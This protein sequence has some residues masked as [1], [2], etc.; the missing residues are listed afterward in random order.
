[1]TQRSVSGASG[2]PKSTRMTFAPPSAGGRPRPTVAA[3]A[4][5]RPRA[6]PSEWRARG[7]WRAATTASPVA[8]T[9]AAGGKASRT[10]STAA[11][12]VD[13]SSAVAAARG[14]GPSPAP[15]VAAH[16]SAGACDGWGVTPSPS[17]SLPPGRCERPPRQSL[18]TRADVGAAP[19][20][21][22]HCR[23]SAAFRRSR[24]R[25]HRAQPHPT[26]TCTTTPLSMGGGPPSH[27]AQ[28]A[29]EGRSGAPRRERRPLVE[30]TVTTV[31]GLLRRAGRL[32]SGQLQ[33]AIPSS[34][35][36]WHLCASVL[37]PRAYVLPPVQRTRNNA[38]SPSA[39]LACCLPFPAVDLIKARSVH[40]GSPGAA[41]GSGSYVPVVPSLG[42]FVSSAVSSAADGAASTPAAAVASEPL[43]APSVPAAAT[44]GLPRPHGPADGTHCGAHTRAHARP[45]P[46]RG[47]CV[48]PA[49]PPPGPPA[50]GAV[51]GAGV[52]DGT[53]ARVGVGV[54]A[55]RAAAAAADTSRFML[56]HAA[57]RLAATRRFSVV[58]MGRP[59]RAPQG[60]RASP[61]RASA[62]ADAA[63]PPKAA[64]FISS[65]AATSGAGADTGLGV[66]DA[67]GGGG[68][69]ADAAAHGR[70]W[71]TGD[72]AAGTDA[73]V[74]AAVRVTVANS[75]RPRLEATI[76]G[77][78]RRDRRGG[79]P[80]D[81]PPPRRARP[82]PP[83]PWRAPR[84]P[85]SGGA[86]AHGA[87]RR[88]PWGGHRRQTAAATRPCARAAPA[89][90]GR[91]P[92]AATPLPPNE[93]A[94]GVGRTAGGTFFRL[95]HGSNRA[96]AR[97]DWPAAS[98]ARPPHGRS[99]AWFARPTNPGSP[100]GAAAPPHARATPP[101]WRLQCKTLVGRRGSSAPPGGWP[102]L[103]AAPRVVPTAA[104]TV[105]VG[106]AP[107]P[108]ALVA[109][110]TACVGVAPPPA[111]VETGAAASGGSR[112]PLSPL[113]YPSWWAGLAA[114]FFSHH[115]LP[116]L[117][118]RAFVLTTCSF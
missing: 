48:A 1:M 56:A 47:G 55:A 117:F 74:A 23:C 9:G 58:A 82:R 26:S 100:A 3:S 109:T 12:A 108:H 84:P 79:A 80:F 5:R 104:P 94:G 93:A 114:P 97:A 70:P 73:A 37:P 115:P 38:P 15:P 10:L 107:R 91:S 83:G 54:A 29:V 90:A 49:A 34:A 88:G 27:A 17:G 41:D 95:Q 85:S 81:A 32:A 103:P 67:A 99:G 96:S 57:T 72:A 42:S 60:P 89:R 16:L 45:P 11:V 76:V 39:V 62:R 30:F 19:T 22:G 68:G 87:S 40:S 65:H 86:A 105:S 33:A 24:P 46:V 71:A 43:A 118:L 63:S 69:A 31:S 6:P 28:E 102:K 110:A 52:C 66:A 92:P 61:S 98:V 2:G 36:G 25:G 51:D 78:E 113:R 116:T 64:A 111:V 77:G 20:V 59:P 8:A 4:G 50:I 18:P 14:F 106:G 53:G 101:R 35:P 13:A 21:C 75:R 112:A 44:G 7:G